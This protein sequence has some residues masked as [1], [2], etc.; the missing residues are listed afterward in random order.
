[1]SDVGFFAAG[2]S[3]H[4]DNHASDIEDPYSDDEEDSD[5]TSSEEEEEQNEDEGPADAEEDVDFDRL[6]QSIRAADANSSTGMLSKD[7]DICMD[8]QEAMFRDDLRGASGIGRKRRGPGK[9][10]RGPVLSQQVRALLGEANQAYIDSNLP[11]TTR[12][13]REVIRIEPRAAPAWAVLAKCFDDQGEKEKALRVRVMGAHLRG[14]AEEWEGLARESRALGFNQQA[15][16]CYAKLSSL[17]PTNISALWDRAALAKEIGDTRTARI[18]LLALLKR[19]PH[20]L[21]VLSELRPIL[22]D[23]GDLTLLAELYQS[24]FE[25]Y[26]SQYPD[27]PPSSAS[28]STEL[29]AI[30]PALQTPT[31][32]S[33]SQNTFG[34]L[35]LLVLADLHNAIGKYDKAVHVVRAGTRWLQGRA[36]ER[37]WDAVEDDR[38]YDMPGTAGEGREGGGYALDVNARHRLAVARIRMGDADEGAMHANI[39]LAQDV[40]DYAPLFGEIADAYMDREMYAQ[41]RP[42]YELLGQDVST[43][44]LYVL[45][46]VARCA[47]MLGDLKD[48]SEVYEH[49]I[50]ADPTHNDAKMRLAEI[51][52]VLGETRKALEL[53]YQVIHSR[54]RRPREQ[55]SSSQA[56]DAPSSSLFEEAPGSKGKGKGKASTKV[57]NRLTPA[58]IKELETKK[59]EEAMRGYARV[60]TLWP[61]VLAEQTEGTEGG[62]AEKEWMLETEKLVEM[63]RETRR[64]FLTTRNYP[65]S[66]M[67]PGRRR[68]KAIEATEED[69]ATRLHIDLEHDR[70]VHRA[71]KEGSGTQ[72]GA[73]GVFRTISFDDWLELF[74]RYAFL[75]SRRGQY[76]VADEVLRHVIFSNAYQSRSMQDTIRFAIITC[77]IHARRWN[78]VVEQYR[79]LAGPYQFNNEPLRLLSATLASGFHATD[80]YIVSTLQKHLLREVRLS[81]AAVKSKDNIRWS[82]RR[83]GLASVTSKG[84]AVEDDDANEDDEGEGEGTAEEK[85]K[86]PDVPTKHNPILVTMY[87]QIALAAKSY[88]SAIFYLLHAYDYCADDPMICLSLAIAYMGRAMQRQ[89][90]NRNHFI[91][92]GMAFLS[93]YREMRK[94][95]LSGLDEVEFN[96]GRAFQQLG[97]HS[98]AVKHYERVLEIA[99]ARTKMNSEA[100]QLQFAIFISTY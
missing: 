34:A 82:G 80:A 35:D 76:E 63:F 16:Y 48:A 42:I 37:F 93:K 50:A 81:D 88:Q 98:L 6:I 94:E 1:M 84:K 86:I 79:K 26:V 71:R 69:I 40:V 61:R 33:S 90:D 58:Q 18:A 27:G 43:S 9:R 67:F 66:G 28:A 12:L 36:R 85:K 29:P 49:V 96:F 3:S 83:W 77:A 68:R 53:V 25:H 70:A 74:M 11:E 15:L 22:V 38:E 19:V 31:S 5:S 13:A 95:D 7:W 8:E 91:A 59:E 65:F 56:A 30:D 100:R 47:H 4:Y 2:S 97:L 92:Q 55:I 60:K 44:S 57:Q 99:E 89:A 24:A 46:Q 75:L 52:E 62:N 45:L 14:D 23:L 32:D 39:V 72:S 54:K 20:D 51:Y 41:A 21:T 10:T 17:D 64:L 73:V 87:G 78:V